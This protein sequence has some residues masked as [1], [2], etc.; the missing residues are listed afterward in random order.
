MKAGLSHSLL[1]MCNDTAPVIPRFTICSDSFVPVVIHTILASE[2]HGD[3]RFS[4]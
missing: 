4:L 2:G 3:L 1:M